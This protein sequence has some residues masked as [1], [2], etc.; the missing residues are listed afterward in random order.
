MTP[1]TNNDQ[2]G[3]QVAEGENWKPIEK[4][5]GLFMVSDKARIMNPRTGKILKPSINHSG[6]FRV[7][8]IAG[9]VLIHRAMCIAFLPNPEN[10]P[11][12]NHI[13]GIKTDNRLTNLEWVSASDNQR[14]SA[15]VLGLRIGANGS[16]A[17]MTEENV[18][19]ARTTGFDTMKNKELAVLFGVAPQTISSA[20]TGDTWKYLNDRFPPRRRIG[21]S[22]KRFR[23]PRSNYKPMP[24]PAVTTLLTPPQH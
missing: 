15:D 10:K 8:T 17:A 21:V 1:T 4:V 19:F 2:G 12:V 13:N 23:A 24:R 9:N 5:K 18:I 14:H 20:I 16:C 7:K 6:Y 11:Q 3:G 22:A